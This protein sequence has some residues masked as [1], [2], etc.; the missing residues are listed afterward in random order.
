M[1]NKLSE[2]QRHQLYE[3]FLQ[4]STSTRPD[5]AFTR[6]T[7]MDMSNFDQELMEFLR[8]VTGVTDL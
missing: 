8:Q 3:K 7:E 1:L 5:S 4:V 2:T 6:T